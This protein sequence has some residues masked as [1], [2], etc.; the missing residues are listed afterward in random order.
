MNVS[1]TPELEEFIK[2]QVDSGRYR[3]ASEAVRAGVRLLESQIRERDL[4]LELLRKAVEQ[5]VV[6]LDRGEGVDGE[7]VFDDLLQ[8]LRG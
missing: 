6:E 5:G 2:E 3:S 1:M 4:K 8:G 7:E